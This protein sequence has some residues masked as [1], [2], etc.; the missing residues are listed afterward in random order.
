[1]YITPPK[2]QN[3]DPVNI[4]QKSLEKSSDV[5]FYGGRNKEQKDKRLSTNLIRVFVLYITPTKVENE[6]PVNIDRKSIKR[7][8]LSPTCSVSLLKCLI[9][10]L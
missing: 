8:H 7:A 5:N 2:V 9:N 1:M 6:D 4:D 10:E 3:E